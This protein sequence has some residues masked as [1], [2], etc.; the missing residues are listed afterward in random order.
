MKKDEAELILNAQPSYIRGLT[1]DIHSSLLPLRTAGWI[2]TGKA[3]K[4]SQMPCVTKLPKSTQP[5]C[6]DNY[7]ICVVC[8]THI[9]LDPNKAL[10]TNWG[11]IHSF[12]FASAFP[13]R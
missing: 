2:M 3:V 9:P 5:C 11:R 8:A 12:V 10:Q 13:A 1:K 7:F 6:R 4:K